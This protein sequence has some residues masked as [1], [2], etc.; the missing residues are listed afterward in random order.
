MEAESAKSPYECGKRKEYVENVLILFIVGI[1]AIAILLPLVL[2]V[3]HYIKLPEIDK[4]YL[5]KNAG[6]KILLENIITTV[7]AKSTVAAPVI[8]AFILIYT[9]IA[10]VPFPRAPKAAPAIAEAVAE[11]AEAEEAPVEEEATKEATEEATEEA[12]E[13]EAPASA[14]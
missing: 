4:T 9:L 5:F 11:S 13:E 7:K 3:L 14:E 12:A 8:D 10:F 1:L 2:V 6:F